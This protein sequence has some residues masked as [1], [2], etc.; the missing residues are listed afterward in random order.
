VRVM[1]RQVRPWLTKPENGRAPHECA[2]ADGGQP[3]EPIRDSG[4]SA[5]AKVRMYGCNRYL[6]AASREDGLARL[7]ASMYSH[8][9][10]REQPFG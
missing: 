10:K 9:E 8:S 5:A 2:K 7:G 4:L 1:A 3:A 6:S